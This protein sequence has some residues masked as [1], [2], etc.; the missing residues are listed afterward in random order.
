MKKGTKKRRKLKIKR[1]ILLIII[2]IVVIGV[3]T[4]SLNKGI[5][6]VIVKLDNM[7]LA[8]DNYLIEVYNYNEEEDK[9]TLD[10][11]YPRGLEVKVNKKENLE[12]DNVNY[13]KIQIDNN[14]YYVNSN[15]IV[16]DKKDIIKEK[17][18]YVRTAATILEDLDKSTIAGFADK[19]TSLEVIG[20]DEVD[21]DGKVNTYKVKT[22]DKEGYI[23]GKYIVLDEEES[24]LN[25]ESDK[26]DAIHSKIKNTYGGGN[27]IKLDFYP[28]EK[29]VF[30]NNKMPSS[31][32]S[33]YLNSSVLNEV[34]SYIEYAKTTKINTF[35]VDIVDDSAIGYKSEVMKEISLSSYEN[36]L[37]SVESYKSAI[38]KIKEAGFYV[39]G[40]ITVFK[41]SYYV[42][43][44]KENAISSFNG[45][46]YLH[47]NSYWPSAYSRDVWY[48]KVAL[49]KEAVKLFGFNEINYDYVRF[50]DRMTSIENS[51]D[52]HNTYNEDKTQA[53]QRFV[54]YACDELHKLE[55]YVSIDV[56]GE[57]T[58]GTYTTAYGQYWPAISNVA[59]VISGMPYPDHF[60]R[61]SYGI[62]KPWNNPYDLMY[63]W[64]SD[65]MKR[66]EECPTP[67]IVRTW[68]QAY[69]VM[70]H[71]DS[72]GISYNGENVKK[73]I[74]GLYDAKADGGYITWNSAS[75]LDKYKQQKS[76][77][78]IDY[79][80][81]YNNENS[82]S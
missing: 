20:Y 52:L 53:I 3:I 12:K 45:T 30:E 22:Q 41:D 24:K 39:I 59:D 31:V 2:L 64:A 58:N 23:Y 16:S 50:P 29:P 28:N 60:A 74:E 66:Q 81:V 49:A 38:D 40:R 13:V 44:H 79:K 65:A 78:D 5:K 35:V 37:H 15:N 18:I 46:P 1:I 8:N 73:E 72:N 17:N 27:A 62:A 19:G 48:Y 33:L 26:Y 61:N 7:Y 34:D 75:S 68:V 36:G 63:A 80:E 57:S 6:E 76:A 54:Q 71:V 55:V 67:A 10:K 25:Y 32:Y 11:E 42:K 4:F 43:D 47:N 9:L 21:K 77:F 56:F 14:N 51:V 82:S 70:K 69:D